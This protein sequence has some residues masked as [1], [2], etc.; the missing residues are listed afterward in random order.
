M[1]VVRERDMADDFLGRKMV[2]NFNLENQL[3]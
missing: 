2:A 3:K 1:V